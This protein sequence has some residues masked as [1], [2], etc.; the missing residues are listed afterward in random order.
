MTNRNGQMI[1]KDYRY[2]DA[3]LEDQRIRR[4]FRIDM[5]IILGAV[6]VLCVMAYFR[7]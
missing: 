4:A 5:T 3:Q 1:K 6:A 7:P 2:Y